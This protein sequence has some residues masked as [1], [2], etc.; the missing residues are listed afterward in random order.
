[1]A[2]AATNG[3][4]GEVLQV[5]IRELDEDRPIARCVDTMGR[6]VDVATSVYRTAIQPAVG[7]IW[8]VDRTYGTWTFA[9][10]IHLGEDD[11]L[12]EPQDGPWTALPL[13][14]GW[15]ASATTGDAP[16]RA[17]VS[18][19][20]FIQLSGVIT[21]GTVPA[22]GSSL[23]VAALPA[24]FPARYRGSRLLATHMPSGVSSPYVRG[25]LQPDGTILIAPAVS[26][27]PT[28]IDL[29]NLWAR[30]IGS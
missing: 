16:P 3:L 27:T 5:T 23:Q 6:Y 29:S 14:N 12:A 28:W 24:G 9:A 17:R 8:L 11:P 25:T 22:F 20:G 26:Y 30:I 18:A 21:G 19:D 7:Q 15:A 2:S 4:G 1:M 10:Y 13:S